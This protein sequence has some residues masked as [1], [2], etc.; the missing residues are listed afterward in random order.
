[1]K[2]GKLTVKK[3]K[4]ALEQCGGMPTYAAKILGVTYCAVWAFMKKN[5]ELNSIRESA[6]AKLHEELE[7]LIIFAIKSGWIQKPILDESGK[8]TSET[9]FEEVDVR[10][11][12][13]YA[14]EIMRQYKGSIGIKDEIDITSDGKELQSDK[15][16]VIQLPETLRPK[17]Q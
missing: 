10:T 14:A 9:Y 8:P 12:M 15:I 3:V 1:M 13:Q 5:P 7:S 4:N 17:S 11:R 6:R 2:R 16:A